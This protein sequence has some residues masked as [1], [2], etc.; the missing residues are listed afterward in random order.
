MNSVEHRLP[1]RHRHS[2]KGWHP[3]NVAGFAMPIEDCLGH[4]GSGNMPL[5]INR[6]LCSVLELQPKLSPCREAIGS[7]GAV[8]VIGVAILG[9]GDY[10]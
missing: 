10:G 3:L 7:G 4:H 6:L 9:L 2:V 1:K 5:G 8:Q